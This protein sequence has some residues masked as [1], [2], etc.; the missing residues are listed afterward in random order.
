MLPE[1]SGALCVRRLLRC[2]APSE[3]RVAP[4]EVNQ[5]KN[6]RFQSKRGQ[7][8]LL[9]TLGRTWMVIAFEAHGPGPAREVSTVVELAMP[10]IGGA[11]G[12]RAYMRCV[13]CECSVWKLA[14]LLLVFVRCQEQVSI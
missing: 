4:S 1:T 5:S 14:G 12:L 2:N 10:F 8:T 9:L 6:A 7:Q 3:P 13:R 11:V